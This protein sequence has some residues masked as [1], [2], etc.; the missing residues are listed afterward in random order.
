MKQTIQNKILVPLLILLLVG[1]IGACKGTKESV[2]STTESDENSTSFSKLQ[3]AEDTTQQAATLSSIQSNK[4]VSYKRDANYQITDIYF[5]DTSTGQLKSSINIHDNNP[6]LEKYKDNSEIHRTLSYFKFD[7]VYL[8]DLVVPD[9]RNIYNRNTEGY[10]VDN[11]Y[12]GQIVYSNEQ[13]ALIGYNLYLKSDYLTVG[14]NSTILI[15]D[16][17]GKEINRLEDIEVS[18]NTAAITQ[19][20]KYLA[21]SFGFRDEPGTMLN[22]GYRIYD[23][24][25]NKLLYEEVIQDPN[26]IA[27]TP[28]QLGNKIVLQYNVRRKNKDSISNRFVMT[29]VFDFQKGKKYKYEYL[30]KGVELLG[31]NGDN[32]VLKQKSG[33]V[34]TI[35]YETGFE[36]EKVILK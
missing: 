34:D 6:Y 19:D 20:M 18:C 13:L 10:I 9:K 28:R 3:V 14:L 27:V 11:G 26:V 33:K 29:L 8:D 21:F 25:N 36:T 15:Y 35:Y 23:L 32:I 17:E 31:I 7:S 24:A 22:A 4:P 16:Q 2:S 5:T 30:S 1:I 12:S